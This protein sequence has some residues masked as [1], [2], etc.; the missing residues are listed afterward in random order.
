MNRTLYL[1][2]IG[3]A[4]L[5]APGA[6]SAAG[7]KYTPESLVALA[8]KSDLLAASRALVNESSYGAEQARAWPALS[9]DLSAGALREGGAS[10]RRY[11][12]A[13]RQ[14]LPLQGKPGLRARLL[15]IETEARRLRGA[16]AELEVTAGVVRLAYEYAIGRRKAEWA[17]ERQQRFE[18][19]GSYMAGRV[20]TTPQQK[21]EG[22]IVRN[23][24][25]RLAAEALR[26]ETAIGATLSE[27]GTFVALG[28]EPRPDIEVPWLAGARALDGEMTAQALENNSGL[29]LQ[30]LALSGAEAEKTL[31]SRERSPDLALFG[32]YE[33]AKA[34]QEE[35]SFTAGVG[36]TLP[37]WNRNRAGIRSAEERRTAEELLLAFQRR[38]LAADAARAAADY[39]A[40]R[41]AV[42]QY[43]PEQLAELR[44][45]LADAEAGFRKGQLDLLTFLE[46]D[47]S[48][49]ETFEYILDSQLRLVTETARVFRLSGRRDLPAQLGAF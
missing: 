17:L 1:F 2:L 10:G 18:L 48:A 34:G 30:A 3:A 28:P 27:L 38:K 6:A 7:E 14:P 41:Q 40:A 12:A 29:R 8:L 46:L 31:A 11:E 9:L 39:E 13:V 20:F 33:R 15:Q 35:R 24:L 25:K 16:D 4:L 32:A 19:I 49:S 47:A 36:L 45:Q 26:L 37:P 5:A 23:R 22:A 42:R 44:V 43:A 21:A